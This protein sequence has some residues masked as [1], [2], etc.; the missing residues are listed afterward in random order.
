MYPTV[1]L[2]QLLLYFRKKNDGADPFNVKVFFCLLYTLPVFTDSQTM[3]GE[4][5]LANLL[6]FSGLFFFPFSPLVALLHVETV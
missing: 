4:I 2:T 1:S 6:K 5:T 3:Q